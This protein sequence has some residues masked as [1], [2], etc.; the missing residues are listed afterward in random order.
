MTYV[1]DLS[2]EDISKACSP[3][4]NVSLFSQNDHLTRATA[5]EAAAICTES[6]TYRRTATLEAAMAALPA[7]IAH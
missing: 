1:F 2:P 3:F 6:A 5:L 7:F 4:A